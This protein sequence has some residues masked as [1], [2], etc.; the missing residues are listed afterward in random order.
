M[1]D[2]LTDIT[3]QRDVPLS[4]VTPLTGAA[5]QR[6]LPGVSAQ[7]PVAAFNSSI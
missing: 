6:L 1:S 3:D 2:Y 4:D 7:V 5:L